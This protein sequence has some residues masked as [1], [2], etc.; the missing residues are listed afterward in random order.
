[1]I[2]EEMQRTTE[3]HKLI[4]KLDV[5]KT[6]YADHDRIGQVLI[7]LLTNAIKYSPHADRIIISTQVNIDEVRLCIQ[8]FG[9]GIPKEAQDK[10]FNQFYRVTGK[11]EE[12]YAGMG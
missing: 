4:T 5:T 7:N 6:I 10:V 2:T 12:T 8:D 3:K 1:E 11:N 9:I